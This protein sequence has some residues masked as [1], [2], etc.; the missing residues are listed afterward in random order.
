MA[1]AGLLK[2]CSRA[3]LDLSGTLH[4][5]DTVTRN[6]PVALQKLRDSGRDVRFVTNTT[7]QSRRGLHSQLLQLG[8]EVRPEEIF[9]SL[10]AARQ[11]VDARGLRPL[12]LLA[13]GAMEE[14]E[15]V[16]TSSPNAVVIGHA[17]EHFHYERLREAFRVLMADE[18][19]VLVAVHKGR[20]FQGSGGFELGLGAFVAGL[21]HS[22]GRH[23]TVVGKPMRE[24]F[25]GAV[26]DMGGSE[27]DLP[28][29]V[30][31]GDDARDDVGGAL[32]CGMQAVLVQTGKYRPGDEA[33]RAC[34]AVAADF[35][36]AVDLLLE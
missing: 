8:F 16:D 34:K 23:A 1:A 29:C 11:L 5:E 17:P 25:M 31:I 3:L 22:T 24:F 10:S 18:T 14:F 20:Y 33:G 28:G 15:G 6:A 19:N 13:D 21:E 27:D 4:I 32:E 7:D 35:A 26:R 12:L 2:R 30:M 9:T 36:A